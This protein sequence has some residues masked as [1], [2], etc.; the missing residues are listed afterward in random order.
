MLNL[1]V[2]QQDAPKVGN[3]QMYEKVFGPGGGAAAAPG[4]PPP[5]QQQAP[6]PAQQQQQ[7][8][9]AP[10]TYNA[11]GAGGYGAPPAGPGG[12]G[13]PPAGAGGYGA[14]GAAPYGGAPP[15]GTGG[16]NP[17]GA[18]GGGAG[19]YGVPAGGVYGA[20]AGG[21]GG[22]GAPPPS[23]PYGGAPGGGGGPPQGNPYGQPPAAYRGAGPGECL[24]RGGCCAAVWGAAPAAAVCCPAM[25]RRGVH[26]HSPAP[27][28]LIAC[29]PPNCH[30]LNY[31]PTAVA[32]NEAPAHIMPI[33]ALNSYQNRWTI[34]ARVTNKSDIRRWLAGSLGWTA[35]V[36]CEAAG[37]RLQSLD[38]QR[39]CCRTPP[40][41]FLT[42]NKAFFFT[43]LHPHPPHH[44]HT[45]TPPPGTPMRG[46]RAASSPLICWTCRVARSGWWPGTTR[47][48]GLVGGW[49]GCVV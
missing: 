48:A 41:L 18:P 36:A 39:N 21:A 31:N 27:Y 8:G 4:A 9:G 15:A 5:M 47:W 37:H 26:Q 23:G 11:P 12:Y 43:P 6:P 3:P 20:P 32:R 24:R 2:L 46:A 49:G 16:P 10:P 25:G 34:K 33:N 40:H 42:N 45:H 28:P 30:S 1:T 19:G 22:Y 14:G 17:Y 44:T 38:M 29:R 7:F 35:G 13:A